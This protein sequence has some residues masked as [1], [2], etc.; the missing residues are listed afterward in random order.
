MQD[1]FVEQMV[2]RRSLKF[3]KVW[4]YLSLSMAAICFFFFLFSPL[5]FFPM[6]AFLVF[7]FFAR[8]YSEVEYE[9]EYTSGTL[10]IDVIYHQE[11]RKRVRSIS[12]DDVT[13]IR[14]AESGSDRPW[15]EVHD[16]SSHIPEAPRYLFLVTDPLSGK[17]F[18]VVLELYSKLL[19]AINNTYPRLIS[20]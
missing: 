8:R 15:G 11:N 20:A 13:E 2:K 5:A 6:A 9:Y 16:Y 1:V 7:A 10:D 17:K 3:M 12:L 18:T 19:G 14:T 4:Q